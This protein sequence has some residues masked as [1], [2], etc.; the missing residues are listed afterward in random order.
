[1]KGLRVTPE[2]SLDFMLKGKMWYG[3]E[4]KSSGA[5][6]TYEENP[7]LGRRIHLAEGGGHGGP[8]ARSAFWGAAGEVG[9]EA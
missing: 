1:M 3:D 7:P 2:V 6:K 4:E 8:C 9:A 5:K